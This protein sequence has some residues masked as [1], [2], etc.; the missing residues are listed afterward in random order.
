MKTIFIPIKDMEI[1]EEEGKEY[2]SIYKTKN[3]VI[4]DISKEEDSPNIGDEVIEFQEV[5][6]YIIQ[7]P[8]LGE[9]RSDKSIKGNKK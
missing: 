4:N 9:I 3:D 7:K 8:K 6:R 1:M 2:T 5:R